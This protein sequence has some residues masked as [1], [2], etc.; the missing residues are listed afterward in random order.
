[1]NIKSG[2]NTGNG[3]HKQLDFL[4]ALCNESSFG[5]SHKKWAKYF[6]KTELSN[7]IDSKRKNK[8]LE[9]TVEL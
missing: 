6:S 5:F 9:I 2:N 7:A 1:M 4:A 8:N 3:T